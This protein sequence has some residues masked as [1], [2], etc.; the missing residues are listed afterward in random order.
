MWQLTAR[1]PDRPTPASVQLTVMG[2]IGVCTGILFG[3]LVSARLAPLFGWDVAALTYL[4]LA[5][6]ALWPMNAERTA[7]LAIHEDPNRAVRDV[8]L[9][10]ACVASLVAVGVIMSTARDVRTGLPRDLYSALGMASVLL[11]WLVV[12]TVFTTRYARVYY[13]GPDGGID[14]HQDL[15][16]CYV[17]FAY[18]AFTV[19]ATFQ[20]SDTDLCSHEMRRTV[21]WHMLVSYLFGAII[22]AATVNL[23]AGFAR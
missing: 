11:S 6:R 10:T 9:L 4:V 3:V 23:V 2:L 17:D 1:H 5:W 13:T 22:I 12:H 7:R 8:L 18:V 14:F 20:I 19:G 16:P 21:L 15:A